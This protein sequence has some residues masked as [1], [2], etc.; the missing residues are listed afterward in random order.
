MPQD[1]FEK[2]YCE[3]AGSGSV[4]MTV[5]NEVDK[6]RAEERIEA[7]G[8]EIVEFELELPEG[9][10][11]GEDKPSVKE[12][13]EK[14]AEPK[15]TA[16]SIILAELEKGGTVKEVA[17]RCGKRFQ[18]VYNVARAADYLEVKPKNDASKDPMFGVR[19]RRL[20]EEGLSCGEIAKELGCSYQVVYNKLGGEI[21]KKEKAAPKPKKQQGK[22]QQPVASAP[23]AGSEPEALA[24]AE[25]LI[26]FEPSLG[27]ADLEEESE[28]TAEQL[29]ALES[30]PMAAI[31]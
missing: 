19:A 3:A 23:D 21:N 5:Y 12:K 8:D 24:E 13:L 26:E 1:H 7:A 6:I 10:K 27:E 30:D 16:N 25:E 31:I 17:T 29:E 14:A 28:P 22:G 15:I 4:D 9:S 2:V 18:H 20:K 11:L